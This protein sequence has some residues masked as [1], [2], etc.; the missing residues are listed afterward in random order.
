MTIR[1]AILRD[2]R[3]ALTIEWSGVAV[4]V[5]GWLL[6]RMRRE[7]L[8][9]AFL[10]FVITGVGGMLRLFRIRCPKCGARVGHLFRMGNPFSFPEDIRFCPLCGVSFDSHFETKKV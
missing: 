7:L 9:L 2:R 10:G 1:E 3:R 5:V 8:V 4:L 6:S